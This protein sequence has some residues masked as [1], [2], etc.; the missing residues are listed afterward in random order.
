MSAVSV[1]T[2]L[3]VIA[4]S[5]RSSV[6]LAT[7]AVDAAPGSASAAVAIS[8]GAIASAATAASP[9]QRRSVPA[10]IALL[11]CSAGELRRDDHRDAE[12]V[13]AF[14]VVGDRHHRGLA[15]TER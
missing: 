12:E 14:V 6:S 9:N 10:L 8:T 7:V 3:F 1:I 5:S 4:H 11:S 2:V 13:D 15:F